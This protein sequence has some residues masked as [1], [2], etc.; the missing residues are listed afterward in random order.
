MTLGSTEKRPVRL[1]GVL[2]ACALLLA[3]AACIGNLD[4]ASRVHDLRILAIS[5]DP[6]DYVVPQSYDPGSGKP[7]SIPHFRIRALLG[8][9]P[10]AQRTL[11]WRI[12]TCGK[13]SA[14][15]CEGVDAGVGEL[16]LLGEG[17]AEPVD[18]LLEVGAE[19]GTLEQLVS[20][21]PLLEDA[22][23][24]DP[25]YGFG[26]LPLV[27]AVRVWAD[28]EEIFGGKRIPF[29][30]PIPKEYAEIVPNRMPPEPVIVFDGVVALPGDV[31]Q[32]KGSWLGLDVFPTDPAL[33]ETYYVP[34]FDGELEK[35]REAWSFAWYTTK[36]SFSPETSGGWDPILKEDA[37]TKTRLEIA[38]GTEP[39]PFKVVC[40]V[41]DGRGGEIWTVR[42]AEYLGP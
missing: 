13:P 27:V 32:V 1:R 19:L 25:Y 30:L 3:A 42:D 17:Q 9:A 37:E 15:R 2:A 28:G 22:M 8:D 33:H 29:W 12:T 40:V 34:T 16:M 35:L 14:L 21:Q 31:P 5:A 6:P 4:R 10:G 18:G 20:L 11:S 36:G 23:K 41:R 39:G 38:E 24:N 26:G 7:P